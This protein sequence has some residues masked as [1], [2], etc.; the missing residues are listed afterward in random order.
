[1]LKKNLLLFLAVTWT[2]IIA[3]FSLVTIG[4]LG[5]SI[6]IPNKDKVVHFI[7]YFVFVILWTWYRKSFNYTKKQALSILVTAIL[8]GILMELFQGVFTTHRKADILDVLAN[9]AGAFVGFLFI[10]KNFSNKRII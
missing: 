7:F 10:N 4:D 6:R 2:V 5:G 9:S 3:I 8:F 1:M